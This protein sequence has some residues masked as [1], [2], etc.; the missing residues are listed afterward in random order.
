[1][2]RGSPQIYWFGQRA[3]DWWVWIIMILL[4]GT[5][6]SVWGDDEPWRAFVFGIAVA[7]LLATISHG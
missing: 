4:G 1:M 6:T 2:W 3:G 5:V 7:P